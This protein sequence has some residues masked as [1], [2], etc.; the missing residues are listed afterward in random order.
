MD[1]SLNIEIKVD[2][3]A[4]PR[5][6]RKVK[7]GVL[8]SG[9]GSNLQALLDACAEPDFPAEI[10]LVISNIPG[11]YA[12]ERAE[13]AGVPTQV[14]R[15]KEFASREEFDA[16]LDAAL[17]AA[18]VELVCLAGFMRLLTPGFTESWRDKLINI[19]PSLL[20]SF[21]GLHTHERALEAGV[22]IHG[23][24]VHIVRPELDEGP[25]IVQGAVPVLPGDTAD[26]LAARVLEVEHRIYPLALQLIAEG[27][28][29]VDGS[30]VRLVDAKGAKKALVNP[31]G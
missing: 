4:R 16:A 22:R 5:V 27:R 10:A 25:I 17:R 1:F 20:P 31:K 9:R 7:V 14:I 15:H 21:R 26:D 8:V 2:A 24:T 29:V 12:L 23:C 3:K 18:E 19:H 30:V 28:A 11:V 13:K 6:E